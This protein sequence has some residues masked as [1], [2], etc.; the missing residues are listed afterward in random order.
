MKMNYNKIKYWNNRKDPNNNDARSVSEKHISWVTNH[1]DE[2]DLNILE[3]G[4]GVG[5]M[6]DSY[7]N[8]KISFYDISDVYKD[9]LIKKCEDLSVIVDEYVIDKSGN[10]TT[11]FRDNQFD[12]VCV[13]EVLLHSPNDEIDDLMSE[14]SRIGKKVMV[15]TWYRDGE[16]ISNN[17]CFTRDYKNIIN[18]NN[19]DLLVWDEK[20]FKDQVAFIYR[21]K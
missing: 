4:P 2:K 19:F 18:K 3:Y 7:K 1:I 8:K 11:Q 16:K 13:F 6:I 17:H 15:I 20:T 10:I 9:R 5:R 14:L 12:L 21:N